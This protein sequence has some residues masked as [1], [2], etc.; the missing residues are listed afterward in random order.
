[1]SYF[2]LHDFPFTT[3]YD[4]ELGWLIREYKRIGEHLNDLEARVKTLE[5]LYKSIPD[6]IAKAT[7]QMQAQV[8][9]SIAQMQSLLNQ[10]LADMNSKVDT[11]L[12]GINSRMDAVEAQI[13][14][15]KIEFDAMIVQMNQ[16]YEKL[17]D[18]VEN[19][20]FLMK[21]W[22]RAYVKEW[23]VKN[24]YIT[25]PTDGKLEDIQTV[26]Y[27][28]YNYLGF[29]IPA[30]EFDAL[31]MTAQEFD[32]RKIPAHCLDRWG[33]FLFRDYQC[34]RMQSPFTGEKVPVQE[35]V[36]ALA[37]LHQNAVTAGEFDDSNLEVE[38]FDTKNVTAYDFDWTSVWFD[39]LKESA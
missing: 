25:D 27:H 21:A 33:K 9:A 20:V 6:E 15:W 4:G 38:T 13:A 14:N 18:Y 10:S 26:V 19:E 5:E 11:A 30:M 36:L 1:M 17:N 3:T 7:A 2:Y 31:S 24:P 34:C 16:L 29:G 12:A 22:V 37:R 35:V 23:A 8:N 39:E 28:M 32:D